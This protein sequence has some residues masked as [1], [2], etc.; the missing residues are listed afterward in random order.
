MEQGTGISLKKKNDRSGGNYNYKNW[1]KNATI[2]NEINEKH[3]LID[4]WR[5]KNPEKTRFTWR[6]TKPVIQSRIDRF[7]ISDTMQYNISKADI[8]P[9]IRSDHSAIVLSIKPTKSVEEG[10]PNFWKFNNSLLN[11]T[12]FTNGLK[13]FI[14]NDISKECEEIKCS[15]VRWE[16]TKYKI[17][18]W[19]IKKS[20]E[21]AR[22]RR[23][24][25][26]KSY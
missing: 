10:G 24:N 17:K 8:I 19:S 14:E 9:G 2:L 5:V 3:D 16:Y 23:K 12:D 22:N 25:E 20:K 1:Q 7:Y 26:K 18:Q 6:R 21:I 15:Q 13:L 4:I 11:N